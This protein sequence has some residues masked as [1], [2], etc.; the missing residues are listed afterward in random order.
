MKP[1]QRLLQFFSNIT[2]SCGAYI[3][4]L[5][6]VSYEPPT[7]SWTFDA[8]SHNAFEVHQITKGR[9]IITAAGVDYPVHAGMLIITGPDVVHSQHADTDTPVEEYCM[10]FTLSK[11][12]HPTR[13][14]ITMLC[15]RL[16]YTPFFITKTDTGMA[17]T[18]QTIFDESFSCHPGYQEI[19]THLTAVWF[20]YL[21]RT[22]PMP[23]QKNTTVQ[24]QISPHYHLPEIFEHSGSHLNRALML[25]G[26]IMAYK[27]KLTAHALAGRLAVSERQLSRIFQATYGMTMTEKINML[28]IEYAKQLF[29]ENPAASIEEVAGQAGY[30]SAQYFTRAFKKRMGMTPSAYKK[31]IA[32]NKKQS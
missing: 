19:I 17:Q 27:E 12:K 5:N 1:K 20:L 23:A 16:E 2:V 22:L 14:I 32:A 24:N 26:C 9:G 13:D 29:M 6:R 18:C 8:H 10:Q 7:A 25:D 3:V 28:R 21:I 15:Q 4:R 30:G 31:Q 11:Q